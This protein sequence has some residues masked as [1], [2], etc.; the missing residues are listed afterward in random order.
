MRND[1]PPD[2]PSRSVKD[3]PAPLGG[4]TEIFDR[5]NIA[6]G[7][8]SSGQ[9]VLA[10]PNTVLARVADDAE[11]RS[12]ADYVAKYDTKE[13]EQIRNDR[14]PGLPFVTV[15]VPGVERELI[16]NESRWTLGGVQSAISDLASLDPPVESELNH[17]V[18]GEQVVKGNPLGA[19]ATWAGEMA[20]LGNVIE[21]KPDEHGVSHKVM[22][23]TAEPA[24][25][26]DSSDDRSNISADGARRSSSST[27]GC[28]PSSRTQ[29]HAASGARHP[30]CCCIR[31][32]RL[33]RR[34]TRRIGSDPD[35][36]RG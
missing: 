24:E 3:H 29:W 16:N 32:T 23:S 34:P 31:C 26:H 13:A 21:T 1:E 5:R 17:V 12:L 20:F 19:P 10:R 15:R 4:L 8:D 35:R 28:A 14:E 30:R 25:G 27:P 2:S 18:F 6:V 36:R 11:R 7:I 33:A 9:V 22:L